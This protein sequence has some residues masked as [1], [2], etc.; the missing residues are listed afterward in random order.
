MGNFTKKFLAGLEPRG[1]GGHLPGTGIYA[2]DCC[3]SKRRN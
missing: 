3:G 1:T 2:Q